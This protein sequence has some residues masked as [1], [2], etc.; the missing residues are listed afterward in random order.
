MKNF[1]IEIL[2]T[3]DSDRWNKVLSKVKHDFYHLPSYHKLAEIMGEGKAMMIVYKED[4]YIICYPF[5]LREIKEVGNVKINGDFK[6]ISSVYGYAGPLKSGKI[7]VDIKRKFI[8]YLNE[9]LLNN[10]VVTL[11]SRLHPLLEQTDL[12]F[13]LGEITEVGPT[14]SIDLTQSLEV[15]RKN[16][17]RS[18]KYQINRLI[19]NGYHV[20]ESTDDFYWNEFIRIYYKTMDRVNAAEYYYFEKSYFDFMKNNMNDVVK[21]FVCI[22]NDKVVSGGIFSLCNKII[23]YHL[24]GSDPEYLKYSP[25]K[26]IFDEV[27]LWG[28][29]MGAEI[30]HLGGGVGGRRDSLFKFKLGFSKNQHTFRIWKYIANLEVYNE[31]KKIA[32]NFNDLNEDTFFPIY[33]HPQLKIKN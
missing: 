31:L 19:R 17:A 32:L 2:T 1:Q 11:F 25:I 22:V 8:Q 18:Y 20:K 26:L 24:G 12:I 27:R 30:F 23:Q 7:P 29:K 33:R 6:D 10:N 3:D 13:E 21:L 14:I 16:Y 9:F 5:L 15:Q 28:N 4:D